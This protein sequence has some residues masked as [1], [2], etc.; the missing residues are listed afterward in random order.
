MNS[1]GMLRTLDEVIYTSYL[2]Y[3]VYYSGRESVNTT[4]VDRLITKM[5]NFL[6]MIK[7][8]SII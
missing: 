7:P 3:I 5:K 4:L 8:F 1:A 6:F 2:V